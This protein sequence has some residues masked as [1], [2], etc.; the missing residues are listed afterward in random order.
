MLKS[1]L[2]P[3]S[4]MV[5]SP[6]LV[7]AGVEIARRSN[8]TL[9]ALFFRADPRTSIPYLGEGLT[10]D[11]IQQICDSAEVES[12]TA[13]EKAKAQFLQLLDASAVPYLD[14]YSH[15]KATAQWTEQV[16][17][18]T[19]NVGRQARTAD[20]SLCLQPD[21]DNPD[22]EDIF[23]ELLFRSG[24][25]VLMMPDDW[26]ATTLGKHALICWNG[27][28]EGARAV[29]AALPILKDA[30]KVTLLQIGDV[31]PDRP[32]LDQLEDYLAQH[33]INVQK[34]SDDQTKASVAEQIHATAESVGA[35]MLVIGA[36]S[37]ARWRELILGG[38]TNWLSTESKIPVFMSH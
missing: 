26:E 18:L 2:L 17:T 19:G 11:M 20:L 8:G 7:K 5:S 22:R 31:E 21:P 33:G 12:K 37:H 25:P 32:G 29:A 24:R 36:Y 4:A 38:V 1:I 9:N 3:L 10:A 6:G 13:A 15:D 23:S 34:R 30:E 16:G 35:D 27:R 14:G 28:V